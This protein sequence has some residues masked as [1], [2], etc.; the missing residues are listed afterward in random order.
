MKLEELFESYFSRKMTESDRALFEKLLSENPE[1]QTQFEAFQDKAK[2][3]KI[4]SKRSFLKS[5]SI[6]VGVALVIV[7][8]GYFLLRSLSM[9]PGEKFFYNYYEPKLS[10]DSEISTLDNNFSSAFESYQNQ[11][12]N[13]AELL[14]EK[15]NFEEESDLSRMYLGLCQLAMER[16]EKAIPTLS[17]ISSDSDLFIEANWYIALGYLKLNKLKDAEKHLK[18]TGESQNQFSDKANEILS[19]MR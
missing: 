12:F 16:P 15:L 11:D 4:T 19:K 6:S 14:F 8:I 2:T 5:W 10:S 7:L 13:R 3:K 1:Y 18:I 17:V 9:T